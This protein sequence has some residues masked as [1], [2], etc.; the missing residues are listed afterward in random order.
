[1]L[2]CVI[3]C[4]NAL[5]NAAMQGVMKRFN[6]IKNRK[7]GDPDYFVISVSFVSCV[8]FV[9]LNLFVFIYLCVT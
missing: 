7:L 9:T 3:K 2:Q 6:D 4:C 5:R 1:M 8:F